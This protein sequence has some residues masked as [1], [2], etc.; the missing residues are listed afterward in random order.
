MAAGW[1]FASHLGSS[2][3]VDFAWQWCFLFTCLRC[4]WLGSWFRPL[5]RSIWGKILIMGCDIG[6]LLLLGYAAYRQHS[7]LREIEAVA[8]GVQLDASE[9]FLMCSSNSSPNS[10]C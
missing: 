6:T 2:S 10:Q 1:I 7:G 4:F 5:P 9:T 3:Q 8:V